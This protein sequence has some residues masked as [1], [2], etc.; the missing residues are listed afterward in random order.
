MHVGAPANT[1]CAAAA[2]ASQGKVSVSRIQISGKQ[3]LKSSNNILYD[4]ETKEELGL[5]DPV[6][7]TIK[8]LPEDD[9][10]EQEEGYESN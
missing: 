4:P 1:Y 5:W 6:S 7:K 9:E 10:E 8:D 2:T 3:Y